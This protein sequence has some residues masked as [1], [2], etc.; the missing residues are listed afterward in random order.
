MKSNASCRCSSDQH[1]FSLYSFYLSIVL[2][3]MF[4]LR[5]LKIKSHSQLNWAKAESEHFRQEANTVFIEG[6]YNCR[7]LIL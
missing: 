1:C 7:I 4:H 5:L 3:F 2:A 6:L